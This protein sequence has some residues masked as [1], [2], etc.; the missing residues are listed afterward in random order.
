MAIKKDYLRPI[1]FKTGRIDMNHGAGGRAA[2][3]LIEEL[4]ARAFE[5]PALREGNDGGS[6]SEAS[7]AAPIGRRFHA[8]TRH[9]RTSRTQY[10][11][12]FECMRWPSGCSAAR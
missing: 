4:F 12:Y 1:D 8:A 7:G 10:A 11:M 2:A 6:G 5:N 3:Q 9:P